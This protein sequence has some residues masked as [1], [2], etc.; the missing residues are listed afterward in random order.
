MSWLYIP[1]AYPVDEH[2]NDPDNCAV[3]DWFITANEVTGKEDDPQ[4]QTVGECVGEQA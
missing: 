1:P 4:P 2:V 3:E